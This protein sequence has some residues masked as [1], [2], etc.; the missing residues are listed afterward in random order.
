MDPMTEDHSPA[1]ATPDPRRAVVF[2]VCLVLVA[3]A[4][5]VFLTQW[6]PLWVTLPASLLVA[7]LA[8]RLDA[9]RRTTPKE[10]T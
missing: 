5:T 6:V 2:I 3:A 8:T 4:G 1:Q 9:R 7:M 10:P